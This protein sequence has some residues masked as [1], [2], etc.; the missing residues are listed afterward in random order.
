M[1]FRVV[2]SA[3]VV[4]LGLVCSAQPLQARQSND[5]PFSLYAYGDNINGLPVF[6]ADGASIENFLMSWHQINP[7]T[8]TAQIGNMSLSNAANKVPMYGM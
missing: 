5:T 1:L 7:R 8:G 6:Y 2:Y 4:F 3:L